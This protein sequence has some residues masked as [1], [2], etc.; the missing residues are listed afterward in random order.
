[1][2]PAHTELAF[3]FGVAGAA[4]WEEDERSGESLEPAVQEEGAGPLHDPASCAAP[5]LLVAQ[6]GGPEVKVCG[7]ID[8]VD[9]DLTG[10]RA[11]VLDY[12]L[13]RPPDFSEIQRGVS[14]QMPLYLLAMERVFDKVGAVACYDSMRE[15]GRRRF[16]R[17]EHVNIRQFQPLMPLDDAPNV[18]PLNRDQFAE[19]TR[20]AEATAVKTA[21]AIAASRVE[22][23]P[24]DHCKFC[25]YRDVCRTT[26]T[27]GHDGELL[28]PAAFAPPAPHGSPQNIP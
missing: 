12:K 2:T 10:Q 23:T 1:M 11:L 26:L 21:R 6:D 25:A 4:F 17:T 27:E 7:T 28:P 9:V 16:H 24:G 8:R 20:T 15:S 14:L 3:G 22:A 19:L 5:L 13:G 18:K